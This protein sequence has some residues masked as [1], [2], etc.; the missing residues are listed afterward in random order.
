MK[1]STEASW[2]CRTGWDT[3]WS[4]K[5]DASPARLHQGISAWHLAWLD[6]RECTAAW[7]MQNCFTA[8]QQ[9]PYMLEKLLAGDTGL[10]LL[11]SCLRNWALMAKTL[12]VYNGAGERQSG[13]CMDHFLRCVSTLSFKCQELGV[14][15]SFT[16]IPSYWFFNL[17]QN[18]LGWGDDSLTKTLAPASWGPGFRF[19]KIG[20][21]NWKIPRSFWDS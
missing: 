12:F 14:M 19:V 20:G 8:R 18:I 3:S 11:F 9:E 4:P 1:G 7:A 17:G 13:K 6:L 2:W 15:A 16:Q 10:D 21:K 5:I